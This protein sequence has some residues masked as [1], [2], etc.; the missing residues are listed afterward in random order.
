MEEKSGTGKE[1][2]PEQETLNIF[3]RAGG[4]FLS[5]GQGF[6]QQERPRPGLMETCSGTALRSL[7]NPS[8][9]GRA[10]QVTARD[11]EDILGQDKMKATLVSGSEGKNPP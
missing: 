1:L 10:G 9:Q 5:L 4:T 7:C 6:S 2:Q 8:F 3:P 11:R